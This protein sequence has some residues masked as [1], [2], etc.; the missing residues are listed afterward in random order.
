MNNSLGMMSRLA[1]LL[2]VAAVL[3]APVSALR[4]E[5][6][7]AEQLRKEV[8]AGTVRL[9]TT[10]VDGTHMAAELA[11]TDSI[12]RCTPATSTSC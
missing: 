6:P 1:V 8:N 12:T 10:D 5:S 2:G 3:A 7:Q 9:L 4:A 11:S